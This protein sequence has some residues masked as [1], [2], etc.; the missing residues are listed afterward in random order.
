MDQHS[1]KKLIKVHEELVAYELLKVQYLVYLFFRYLL[2]LELL[3]P[4]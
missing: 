1:A 4:D 2:D 3:Y